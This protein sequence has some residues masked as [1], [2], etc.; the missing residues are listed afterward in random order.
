MKTTH[1]LRTDGGGTLGFG[2]VS[3][4]LILAKV[5]Q[6]RGG[7]PEIVLGNADAHASGQIQRAGVSC[8]QLGHTNMFDASDVMSNCHVG[9]FDFSH[10][11]T[12]M[13]IKDVDQMF[14]TLRSKNARTLLID[15]K[16][17]DCLSS[18]RPMRANILTIPYAGAGAQDVLPGADQDLRGLS[19]CVLDASAGKPSHAGSLTPEVAKRI[20]VTAGGSD[21]KALTLFFMD[22]LDQITLELKLRIII[23]PGFTNELTKLIETRTQNI[24]H[25]VELVKDPPTLINE[26]LAT[27]CALSA[28]GLTKHELAY[29]GT[30]S[31]LVSIDRNHADANAPF[32]E[33]GTCHDG[34]ELANTT[35]TGV[36]QS[37][38]SLLVDKDRR[39][40]F[41]TA[42]LNA[43]DGLGTQRLLEV[44]D[45]KTSQSNF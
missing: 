6:E 4:C 45:E 42:G 26:M 37:L 20:L 7:N 16:G 15:A 39:Q 1:I 27:D 13:R 8:R 32:A 14:T 10:M 28:S 12:R 9:I 44:L 31:L 21:P 30:P 11:Q 33:L 5:I 35:A 22:A 2:H 25:D 24:K 3:R 40:A 36:A 38:Q 17:R 29:T 43:I 34:G 18:I 23:G 19:Y 41:A